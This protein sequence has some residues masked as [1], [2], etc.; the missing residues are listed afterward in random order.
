MSPHVVGLLNPLLL[1][2]S[3]AMLL[4]LL[5]HLYITLC[6]SYTS[7]NSPPQAPAALI[8]SLDTAAAAAA[9]FRP[10]RLL[11]AAAAQHAHLQGELI[12]LQLYE[13]PA[14]ANI[15]LGHV[16]SRH[17]LINDVNSSQ[18][19]NSSIS[20]SSTVPDHHAQQQQ[21]QQQQDLHVGNAT[22]LGHSSKETNDQDKRFVPD[23]PNPLHNR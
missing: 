17:T 19:S 20:I 5:L 4:C 8:T 1:A 10:R 15:S 12:R 23:G 3:L 21:Q 6:H 18:L 9:P 22:H 11:L 13:S 16:D 14:S 7:I 2:N